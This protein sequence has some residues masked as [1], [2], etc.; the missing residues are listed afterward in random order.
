MRYCSP[1]CQKKHWKDG[2]KNSCKQLKKAAEINA[3]PDAPSLSTRI[4]EVK[5]ALQMARMYDQ[6]QAQVTKKLGPLAK[7]V[8]SGVGRAEANVRRYV[9]CR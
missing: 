8:V 4:D 3:Q 9:E 1:E 5:G 6:M 2:H 7:V